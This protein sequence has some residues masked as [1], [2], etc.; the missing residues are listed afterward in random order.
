[1]GFRERLGIWLLGTKAMPQGISVIQGIQGGGQ[2]VIE[3]PD[4]PNALLDQYREWVYACVT[5]NAESLA[6]VSLHLYTRKPKV[7]S[8]GVRHATPLRPIMRKRRL[9]LESRA[10]LQKFFR[11]DDDVQ[12]VLE[13]PFLGLW[14]SG[15]PFLTGSQLKRVLVMHM[16]IVGD[17]YT[18]IETDDY[19]PTM[20]LCLP[21]ELMTIKPREDQRGIEYYEQS[22]RGQVGKVRI[23]PDRIMH[24]K[25]PDPRNVLYGMSPLEAIGLAAKL[26]HDYNLFEAGL[27]END[28]IPGTLIRVERPLTDTQKRREE[29]RWR[30]RYGGPEKVG[31]VA[32]VSGVIGIDRIGFSQRDMNFQQGRRMTREDIAGVFN[33][34][35][36][37]LVSDGSALARAVDAEKHHAR[38]AIKPRCI[39]IEEQINRD[40]IS[41][42][43]DSENI[44]VAFDDPV[45]DDRE[46]NLKRAQ[47]MVNTNA[48]VKVN[49]ARAAL[50]LSA[51]EGRE[52]EYVEGRPAPAPF[53]G[54]FGGPGAGEG[55][56]VEPVKAHAHKDVHAADMKLATDIERTLQQLFR[57]QRREFM[58]WLKALDA[59]QTRTDALGRDSGEGGLIYPPDSWKALETKVRNPEGFDVE[60][61]TQTFMVR[62][63]PKLQRQLLEGGKRGLNRI[64]SPIS[65]DLARPEVGDFIGKYV[66]RFSFSV[67][68]TTQGALRN[69]FTEA[70][71]TGQTLSEVTTKVEGYFDFSER[72]RATRIA[73][74]ETTRSRVAGEVE[75][76]RQSGVVQGYYWVAW[77]PE[78]CA[79]CLEVEREFGEN[80]MHR[81]F[82]ENF[83]NRGTSV[84]AGEDSMELDYSDIPHA[85]LHPNCMCGL[86]PILSE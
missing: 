40:I 16:D 85:P 6:A 48:L 54:G 68:E 61:W 74:T 65:F 7:K 29:R 45:P 70:H 81:T 22:Q 8:A 38:Y 55:A 86:E 47:V 71:E 49:E 56:Q 77:G 11:T 73:A 30:Q 15:N 51:E 21:P 67:N 13:H 19:G 5:K 4:N 39:L 79:F 10:H 75:G 33:V 62:L 80:G 53:G 43:E 28:G 34:P 2:R 84:E 57:A 36:P 69:I 66:Y 60:G 78:P 63:Q 64:N 52:E 26:Y 18:L 23:P 3:P 44:F 24:C 42:Y 46:Y 41:K 32:F 25:H 27:I 50:E 76:W 12:E 9:D 1:M 14:D 35:M 82:G 72:Y 37:L 83:Y 31:K 59:P 20:L 58:G 17:S